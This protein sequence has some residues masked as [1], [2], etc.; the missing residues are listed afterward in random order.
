[1][2]R[3]KKIIGVLV[4][5]IIVLVISIMI[6][7]WIE[8]KNKT[9]AVIG[10]TGTVIVGE[11][12]TIAPSDPRP[13]VGDPVRIREVY[14]K[15]KTYRRSAVYG[16]EAIGQHTQWGLGVDYQILYAGR[17][18]VDSK[19]EENDGVNIVAK[20]TVAEAV[21]ENARKQFDG[22]RVD[23]GERAHILLEMIG[24]AA[25][26]NPV[27]PVPIPPGSAKLAEE[28]VN[29]II[30][31]PIV[32]SIIRAWPGSV[33][34]VEAIDGYT[35]RIHFTDGKGV[36]NIELLSAP[37]YRDF[38]GRAPFIDE[39]ALRE[40][41]QNYNP[42]WDVAIFPDENVAVGHEWQVT[43]AS[44][45]NLF[46]PSMFVRITDAVTMRRE[47]DRD[48]ATVITVK[49]NSALG[50]SARPQG[51]G[52]SGRLSF[53]G[54]TLHYDPTNRLFTTF[55]LNGKL[56]MKNFSTDHLLFPLR[57]AVAPVFHVKMTTEELD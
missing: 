24:T 33:F 11:T 29:R 21:T 40:F 23:L 31:S 30:R 48:A 34:M 49:E 12:I 13:A 1:M 9:G 51:R 7:N 2:N 6:V 44:L 46:T 4:F 3:D 17:I 26:L 32:E 55:M 37:D 10:K 22:V 25:R 19:I 41:A 42:I 45:P 50:F 16:I 53:D 35:F 27:Y 39:V 47:Q 20:V 14:Q 57:H 56:P 54:G 38:G 43:G 15:G 52:V 36:T 18:V 5:I 8:R 28:L